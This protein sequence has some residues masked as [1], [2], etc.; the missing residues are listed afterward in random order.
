M[1]NIWDNKLIAQDPSPHYGPSTIPSVN[2][3]ASEG[4]KIEQMGSKGNIESLRE[5]VKNIQKGRG[6]TGL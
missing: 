6:H 2:C 4:S 5:G 3:E 1:E